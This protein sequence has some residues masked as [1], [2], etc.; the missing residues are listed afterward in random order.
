MA[1]KAMEEREHKGRPC[2]NFDSDLYESAG[3]G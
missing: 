1:K 2:C 3:E